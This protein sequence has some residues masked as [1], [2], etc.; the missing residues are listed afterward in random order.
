MLIPF[1]LNKITNKLLLGCYISG[2][3]LQMYPCQEL[4]VTE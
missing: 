2:G 1:P 4:N 3:A